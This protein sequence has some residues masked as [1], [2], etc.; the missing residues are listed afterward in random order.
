LVEW[1][2]C[3][4]DERCQWKVNPYAHAMASGMHRYYHPCQCLTHGNM[5]QIQSWPVLMSQMCQGGLR[6]EIQTLPPLRSSRSYTLVTFGPQ[7]QDGTSK[8]INPYFKTPTRILRN[9]PRD[10]HRSSPMALSSHV[11]SCRHVIFLLCFMLL[12]L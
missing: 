9:H 6:T 1:I 10:H 12:Q 11:W 3:A 8:I 7:A 5:G 2:T 4:N